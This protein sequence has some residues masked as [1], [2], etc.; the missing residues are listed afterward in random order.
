M[1]IKKTRKKYTYKNKAEKKDIIKAQT[2]IYTYED[3][4]DIVKLCLNEMLKGNLSWFLI[5]YNNNI[6][7]LTDNQIQNIIKKVNIEFANINLPTPSNKH[8]IYTLTCML[9]ESQK[10]G[11]N[12]TSLEIIQTISNIKKQLNENEEEETIY[13]PKYN[14]E[15]EDVEQIEI[16][17]E[18][19]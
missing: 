14:I 6:C 5:L 17:D 2:K 1:E 15:F 12:R 8:L 16:E 19:N 10:K 7:N 18:S 11:H 9:Y 3:K 4:D 13:I